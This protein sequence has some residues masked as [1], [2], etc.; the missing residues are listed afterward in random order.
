MSIQ[1][2][3]ELMSMEFRSKELLVERCNGWMSYKVR[4]MSNRKQGCKFSG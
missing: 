3:T 4:I 2:Q 1:S